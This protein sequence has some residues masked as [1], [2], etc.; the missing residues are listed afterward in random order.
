MDN[1]KVGRKVILKESPWEFTDTGG[2]HYSG[3]TYE[4]NDPEFEKEIE[5]LYVRVWTPG[6]R[7]T[8]D[9]NTSRLNIHINKD[10]IITQVNYG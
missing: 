9:W 2:K 6:T 10:G 3:I 5:G 1:I 8:C 4:V 7:G